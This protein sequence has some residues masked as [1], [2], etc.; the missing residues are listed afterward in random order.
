VT[1][2][3]TWLMAGKCERISGEMI[4]GGANPNMRVFVSYQPVGPVALLIP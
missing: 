3:Y 1:A 2:S 4:K